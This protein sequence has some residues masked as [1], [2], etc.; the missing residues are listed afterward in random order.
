MESRSQ[1]SPRN[2]ESFGSNPRAGRI[3]KARNSLAK[4]GILGDPETRHSLH[5][6]LELESR[7]RISLRDGEDEA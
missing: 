1:E 3:R 6:M 4:T 5:R 2:S 7:A